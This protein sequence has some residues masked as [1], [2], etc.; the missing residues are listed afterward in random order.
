MQHG[1]YLYALLADL[2]WLIVE[3]AFT[4]TSEKLERDRLEHHCERSLK[5]CVWSGTQVS[6][7]LLTGEARIVNAQGSGMHWYLS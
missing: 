5:L 6:L 3:R 1:F 4:R 2:L 7:L